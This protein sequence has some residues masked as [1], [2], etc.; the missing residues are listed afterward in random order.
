MICDL[1]ET[2]K[3]YD[4]RAFSPS[5]VGTLCVGLRNDSRV[6]MTLTGQKITLDQMLMARMCDELAFQSWA[7]SKDGQRNRNRPKSIL[8]SLT[9]EKEEE[10]TAYRT[11]DEFERAWAEIVGQANG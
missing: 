8:K 1:A 6:K 7:K 4:Y 9:E 5:L 3:I 11:A 10:L 2:Y